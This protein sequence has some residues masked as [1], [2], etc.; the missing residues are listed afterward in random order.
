MKPDISTDDF[1]KETAKRVKTTDSLIE[2]L[3]EFYK[4]YPDIA[5][6]LLRTVYKIA[7]NNATITLT[8]EDKHN[9]H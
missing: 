1:F 9:E 2:A 4:S 3:K 8:R 6:I 7:E 5:T